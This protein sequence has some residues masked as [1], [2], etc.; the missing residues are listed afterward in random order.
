MKE[1]FLYK[2]GNQTI[3]EDVELV[4]IDTSVKIIEKWAFEDRLK[5][6]L[7]QFSKKGLL[8]EIGSNAFSNCTS[9]ESI[10]LPSPMIAVHKGAFYNCTSL[11]TV[12]LNEGL[13]RIEQDAFSG[14]GMELLW[15]PS[16][17]KYVRTGSFDNCQALR[18]VALNQGLVKLENY[19]FNQCDKL[20]TIE[21]M[22]PSSSDDTTTT[23]TI[24]EPFAIPE[25]TSRI[26][27]KDIQFWDEVRYRYEREDKARMEKHGMISDQNDDSSARFTASKP[28]AQDDESS[29]RPTM[30]KSPPAVVF[31]AA[32]AA[33]A[34]KKKR[35]QETKADIQQK[36]ADKEGQIESLKKLLVS[37]HR[38]RDE[39]QAKLNEYDH[40]LE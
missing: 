30:K 21:M 7:V 25:K 11:K 3:P 8:Q 13:E 19:A 33:P 23:T 39:L 38:E 6:Q 14:C 10:N 9:L 34:V 12:I 20:E 22:I 29:S 40:M 17:V 35:K 18:K 26:T 28:S 24:I 4:R 37:A 16:T 2:G 15:L 1:I 32:A 36:L 31:P 5:L 27:G